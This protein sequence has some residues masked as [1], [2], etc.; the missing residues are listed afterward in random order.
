MQEWMEHYA[1]EK[2]TREPM[3]GAISTVEMKDYYRH[4]EPDPKLLL[5][6]HPEVVICKTTRANFQ[7]LVTFVKEKTDE[8]GPCGYDKKLKCYRPM[9]QLNEKKLATKVSFKPKG[10][11]VCY[12]F[13]TKSLQNMASALS[14]QL[15]GRVVAESCHRVKF[16]D[17]CKRYWTHV[18][19]GYNPM[20]APTPRFLDY[21]EKFAPGKRD[22]YLK[23]I[24]KQ[25]CGA[26]IKEAWFG[27]A[28]VKSG[29]Q[30]T[31]T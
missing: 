1:A 31:D 7:A 6:P 5:E 3:T 26:E 4:K 12:E 28:M 2:K 9:T 21:P 22:L 27:T 18:F 30:Y 24:V 15:S 23:Q 14:R 8:F 16:Q 20:D 13:S 10:D 19:K 11:G 29:E 25:L 17:M